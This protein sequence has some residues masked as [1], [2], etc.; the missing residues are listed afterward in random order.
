MITQ[1]FHLKLKHSTKMWGVFYKK[2]L[3]KSLNLKIMA[4][5]IFVAKLKVIFMK[6]I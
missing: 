3:K 2:F 5:Y 1:D 4:L 6:G